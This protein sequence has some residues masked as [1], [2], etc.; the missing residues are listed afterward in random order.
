MLFALLA[1]A[2]NPNETCAEP[3]PVGNAYR[4]WDGGVAGGQVTYHCFQTYDHT[5]GNT[6]RTCDP[7]AGYEYTGEAPV[8]TCK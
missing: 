6:T 3:F 2:A 7:N 8:C 4:E 1:S 5:Y